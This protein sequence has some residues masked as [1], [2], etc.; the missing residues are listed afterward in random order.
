M[1]LAILGSLDMISI[2]IFAETEM[3]QAIP[4]FIVDFDISG[5]YLW[6]LLTAFLFVCAGMALVTDNL[7]DVY[8]KGKVSLITG[9]IPRIL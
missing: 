1:T 6:W 3:L 4:D 2:S 8:E 7:A 5:E 9:W